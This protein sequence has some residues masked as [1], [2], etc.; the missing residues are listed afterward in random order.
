VVPKDSEKTSGT[1]RRARHRP[2]FGEHGHARGW[3]L[4][5]VIG[6]VAAATRGHG[7]LGDTCGD[8]GATADEV[9]LTTPPE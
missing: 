3:A 4:K 2:G 1:R 8:G 6:E 9:A 5:E 7:V